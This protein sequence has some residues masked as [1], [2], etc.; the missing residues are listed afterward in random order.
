VKPLRINWLDP[1]KL[2]I[3]KLDRQTAMRVFDAVLHFALHASGD[4]KPLRGAESWRPRAGDYRVL[5]TIKGST[6][7]ISGVRHRSEAY[8]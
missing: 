1:A 5:F 4:V 8:R 6:M 3:R 7:H 2:D